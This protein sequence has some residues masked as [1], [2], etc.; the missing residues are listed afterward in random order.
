MTNN[1][2]KM[3]EREKNKEEEEEQKRPFFWSV[4]DMSTD[5]Q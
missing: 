3:R 1:V 2:R 5:R 4:V